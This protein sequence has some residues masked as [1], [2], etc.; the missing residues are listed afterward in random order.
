MRSLAMVFLTCAVTCRAELRLVPEPRRL[1]PG[2][3]ELALRAPV[4]IHVA[5]PEDRAAG[6]TLVA[7]LGELHNLEAQLAPAGGTSVRLLRAGD[8]AAEEAIRRLGL[9]REALKHDEGYLLHSDARG[10]LVIART[11]AGVF[12]GAQTLRQLIRPGGRLP[13]V[14]IAD[15]PALRYRGLSVDVSRGPIPHREQLERL[16]RIAAEFKLNMLSLYM[17][18]VFAYSHAPLV[19]PRGGEFTKAM[20]HELSGLARRYHIELVPQ[21]QTFGHL[22]HMLKF[23]RYAHM[24]EVPYGSVI[25]PAEKA[26]YEWIE[27]SCRQLAEAF[28]GTFLHIGSD[29]TW[30]L[31]QGRSREEAERI[32]VGRLYLRHLQRVAELLRP[33]GRRLMFW[34]DIALKHAE[35]IPELPRDLV[36]MTWTY[37][38]RESFAD[39]IEPFRRAGL[40]FFV[41]PGLNNWN[42]VFP[43]VSNALANIAGFVRDGKRAGAL[44]MF[45]THWADDGEALLNPNWY[46]ILYS[47]AA[48]W[49]ERE[50]SA[51]EFEAA[52]DWAFYRHS[53][54]TFAGV[55]R[56]LDQA[57]RILQ[58]A[59]VGDAWNRLFWLD[60]FSPAGAALAA[61]IAPFA[62][63]L[64]LTAE[65]ALAALETAEKQNKARRFRES[66]LSLELAARRLDY[67]GMKV[68]YGRRIGEIYREALQARAP[69][70]FG[71]INAT[72]GMLQDLRDSATELK[73]LCRRA[74]LAENR[75]YWLENV[76]VRYDEEALLWTRRIRLF[77]D[78]VQQYNLWQRLPAPEELGLHLP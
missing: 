64:R 14:S 4:R 1:A 52:F 72:N 48:A 53:D 51:A 37:D 39:F 28:P 24:A 30:E 63:E 32:G 43:N 3:G 41:C 36:A 13:A 10:A 58:R 29:E 69:R 11:A 17:E 34:G 55:I 47:A 15:W 61:R 9:D 71:R 19:A 67:L 77:T 27:Q 62:A 16:I 22:H 21:Q 57:H 40:A 74:W 75:P 50:P 2:K 59:G 20:V 33:L 25:T 26:T 65:E 78:A 56:R 44:G 68:Q 18:H 8:A 42:R 5:H 76:L 7:E 54:R 31:G 70:N 46:G 60:P 6:E 38:P 12:Y 23:E 73:D 45:N 49:Q 66:L 35:L